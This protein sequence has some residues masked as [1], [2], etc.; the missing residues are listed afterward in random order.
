[1]K[2]QVQQ[3]VVIY[4][5]FENS[6]CFKTR[7]IKVLVAQTSSRSGHLWVQSQQ[8]LESGPKR[9][10]AQ[11]DFISLA[12]LAT[13]H[14]RT[15]CAAH[16]TST[17]CSALSASAATRLRIFTLHTIEQD[18][19][20]RARYS[21]MN[22]TNCSA[23]IH[24]AVA[25]RAC[26]GAFNASKRAERRRA[27]A[28]RIGNLCVVP[29]ALAVALCNGAAPPTSL[30]SLVVLVCFAATGARSPSL[31]FFYRSVVRAL[32]FVPLL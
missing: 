22:H 9:I 27:W 6:Q 31:R 12:A 30:C 21:P 1:M 5:Q 16:S 32:R 29:R 13:C 14:F 8:I 7:S 26:C 10:S 3:L 24:D 17:T 20:F 11:L 4:E 19:A 23:D 25:R 28:T 18:D 15:T 2:N